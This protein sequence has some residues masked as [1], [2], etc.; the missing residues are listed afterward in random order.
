MDI[1]SGYAR[2]EFRRLTLRSATGWSQRDL[3]YHKQIE[4]SP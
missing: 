2:E 3:H 4:N 1:V